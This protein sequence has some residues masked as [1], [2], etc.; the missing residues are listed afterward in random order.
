MLSNKIKFAQQKD[1]VGGYGQST[2]LWFGLSVIIIGFFLLANIHDILQFNIA[3]VFLFIWTVSNIYLGMVNRNPNL[4]AHIK[5]ID[6]FWQL[7]L[8][9]NSFKWIGITLGGILLA[10][11]LSILIKSPLFG[12]GLAGIALFVGFQ[13]TNCILVPIIA[14]GIYNSIVVSAKKSGL[15]WLSGLSQSPIIVPEVGIGLQGFS[16][17]YT[18]VMWQFILVATSEELMK[19]A[20]VV[21]T[22]SM[23]K[24]RFEKGTQVWI[25]GIVSIVV[26]VMLHTIQAQSV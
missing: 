4:F 16:Q 5:N 15:D 22:V 3:V 21:F 19:I 14:H 18:E 24:Q 11:V 2:T 17:L 10:V 7:N 9:R 26:W 8:D 6:I 25:G 23:I 20:I 1:I 13:K 12:I